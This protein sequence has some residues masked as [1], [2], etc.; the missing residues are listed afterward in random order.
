MDDEEVRFA[1]ALV[2]RLIHGSARF[3][4]R[5]VGFNIKR[6]SAR[7]CVAMTSFITRATGVIFNFEITA[8][9]SFMF[10]RFRMEIS[11]VKRWPRLAIPRD[12]FKL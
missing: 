12:V 9:E 2:R 10:R 5:N 6:L 1:G 4:V 3:E 11:T 8:N 7:V